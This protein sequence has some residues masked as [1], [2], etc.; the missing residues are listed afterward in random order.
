MLPKLIVVDFC[1]LQ[2]TNLGFGMR[3]E[4]SY[5][6][7][8]LQTVL[9]AKHPHVEIFSSPT[10]SDLSVSERVRGVFKHNL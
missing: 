8:E 10:S 7:C 2:N 3:D 5:G 9:F 4:I 1:L 6:P